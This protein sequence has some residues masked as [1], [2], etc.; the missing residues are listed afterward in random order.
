VSAVANIENEILALPTDA[1]RAIRRTIWEEERRRGRDEGAALS[2][3]M[4][5][6]LREARERSGLSRVLVARIAGLSPSTVLR[7][8]SGTVNMRMRTLMALAIT[9]GVTPDWLFGLGEDR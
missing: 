7:A 9:Y 3:L 1:L 8:E 6:R 5:A 2:A 4:G